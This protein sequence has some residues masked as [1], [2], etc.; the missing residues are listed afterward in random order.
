MPIAED[1]FYHIDFISNLLMHPHQP[2]AWAAGVALI[3]EEYFVINMFAFY[4]ID[5]HMILILRRG[6]GH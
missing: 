4:H 3:R 2:T 1:C 5:F 6:W